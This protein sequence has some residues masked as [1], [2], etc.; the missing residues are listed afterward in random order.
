MSGV[1][2]TASSIFQYSS[3]FLGG[4]LLGTVVYFYQHPEELTVGDG[5]LATRLRWS[6]NTA[7]Q[8]GT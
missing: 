6:G 5:S 3:G 4:A 1:A 2:R 8:V 7:S